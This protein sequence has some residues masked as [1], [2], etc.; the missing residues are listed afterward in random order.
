MARLVVQ[1]DG[2]DLDTIVVDTETNRIEIYDKGP[3]SLDAPLEEETGATAVL[4]QGQL[5]K[6]SRTSLIRAL[7]GRPST[8]EDQE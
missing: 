5:S 2:G 4:I 8:G 1:L 7:G 3:S 6:Q